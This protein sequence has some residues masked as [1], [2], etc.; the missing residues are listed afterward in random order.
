MLGILIIYPLF[1]GVC[2]AAIFRP[3]I[4]I[5]GFYGCVLLE[6][7]W[8]WRWSIPADFQFQK[9]IALATVVGVLLTGFRGNRIGGASAWATAALVS[10]LAIAYVS[11][12]QT[13]DVVL[14]TFYM[15]NMWKI[16]MMAI[17][18]IILLDEPRKILVMVAVL[19]ITQGYSAYQI[20][21]QYFQDGVS[22]YAYYPWGTKGDNNLYSNLTVPLIACSAAVCVFT[23]K[24]WLRV[25]SGIILIL[26][27]HQLMLMESRGAMLAAIAMMGWF[28]FLMPKT[29]FTIRASV[30]TVL[31][32]ALLAGPPV[33]KEFM[34]SF[35]SG[36]NRDSSA[37]SRFT[38]WKAGAAITAD[39]PLLG[40]GPL[41][42][43][44][45]VPQ[46]YEGGLDGSQKGLHNLVF[47]IS[48]GCGIPAAILYFLFFLIPW[49]VSTKQY[50][51]IARI[52][53]F[54]EWKGTSLLAV[55]T[56]IPGYLAASMFSSGA[57][58]EPSY[59]LA[60]VGCATALVAQR[61][62]AEPLEVLEETEQEMSWTSS[63]SA[64][65][66]HG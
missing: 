28:A 19:A 42:G 62:N 31:A 39:Y 13:I 4:G 26:Q 33:Y 54:P 52:G 11:A 24:R 32:G 61:L 7:N 53:E 51:A 50:W 66:A 3:W 46:Y 34:S 21:L 45:L 37:D 1:A 56:G 22:I 41:A 36:E 44:R 49:W 35:E 64:T 65:H 6:P 60:S 18:A 47:E 59:V 17:L 43:Q 8:N 14:T 57:L 12:N 55:A 23:S 58:L 9:Y 63:V 2:I 29:S 27:M 15:E 30:V 20:N 40:V 10:F 38:L 48:T 25:G 5:V 16:V